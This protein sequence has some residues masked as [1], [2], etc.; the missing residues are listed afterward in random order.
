VHR[1]K[2]SRHHRRKTVE[3]GESGAGLSVEEKMKLER[4][5]A[6][7]SRDSR[8]RV[9]SKLKAAGAAAIMSKSHKRKKRGKSRRSG[10]H[11]KKMGKPKKT[12]ARIVSGEELT[13]MELA[14]ARGRRSSLE[15]RLEQFKMK[16]ALESVKEKDQA[17]RPPASIAT[18]MEPLDDG[19]ADALKDAAQ[20]A[21]Q[22]QK[23]RTEQRL[24]VRRQ[25]IDAMSMGKLPSA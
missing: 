15:Q 20:E 5:A 9:K 24:Q 19:E 4:A 10:R 25:S 22:A 17:Q 8:Q 12:M 6:S 2:S 7:A 13:K 23:K 18:I 3:R 16:A 11:G 14:K 21:I 1:V